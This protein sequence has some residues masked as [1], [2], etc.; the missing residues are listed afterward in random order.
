MEREIKELEEYSREYPSV[1]RRAKKD[2]DE[3]KERKGD[4]LVK[5]IAVQSIVCAVAVLCVLALNKVG[6]DMF[7]EFSNALLERMSVSVTAAQAKSAFKYI[8]QLLPDAQP[9]TQSVGAVVPEITQPKDGE[10]LEPAD[11]QVSATLPA[12]G[13]EDV[14]SGSAPPDAA[15]GT[16]LSS[17]G[18]SMAI[19][20]P[21]NGPVTSGFGWRTHP[22]NGTYGF[23]TGIDIGANE[24]DAI[25]AAYPGTVCEAGF[26][27]NG[28]NYIVIDHGNGVQT[29]YYHC[30]ALC[31]AQGTVIREGER[32]AAV[33]ST[34]LST[35]PHLH[36]E[37][38]ID[39]INYDPAYA[40]KTADAF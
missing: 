7:D 26:S 39:G 13:G 24:G 17:Y 28:G 4:Y 19:T 27:E 8:A 20:V 15:D 29:G 9:Q 35:G 18:M 11:E 2:T 34:G 5:V 30:S 36:F 14:M 3:K 10:V 1:R 25:L 16:S 31:V 32:I 21:V 22:V 40:L 33:G 12:V 6:G 23:H 38:L 37:V